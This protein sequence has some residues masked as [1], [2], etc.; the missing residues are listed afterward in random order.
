M[1]IKMVIFLWKRLLHLML[2]VMLM[3]LFASGAYAQTPLK[4]F[5]V[6]KGQIF[7]SLSKNLPEISLDS[8]IVQYDLQEL[9]LKKFIK[10]SIADSLIKYGWRIELNNG[11]MVVVSKSMLP[12]ETIN[13]PVEKILFAQKYYNNGSSFANKEPMYDVNRFTRKN[14][15]AVND[16]LVTFFL[17][18]NKKAGKVMLAGTFN[19]WNPD[20][21][22]MQA[23]DSGWIAVVELGA[24]KHY[25]KFIVDG[26]WTVDK[27]NQLVENDGE[28]N[29]NS[30]YF[31][32]NFK[33]SLAAFSSAKK[34]YI[35][36][37]FNN[38]EPADISMTKTATGWER[39]VYLAD[40]THTYRF[41]ADG[42]WFADP[43]N[44]DQFPNEFNEA[45]SVIRKGR[46]IMFR[47][48][49]FRNAKQVMLMGSFNQ[50]RNFE[51]KMQLTDSGW[52][53]PYTLG[54]G[55][56]EYIFEADGK[57]IVNNSGDTEGENEILVIAPNTNFRLK[58]FTNAKSVYLAGDFNNWSPN[59]FAMKR[60]GADWVIEQHLLPGK[61][62]YKFV[63]DGK[64]IVDTDNPLREPNEFGE[65]NSVIWKEE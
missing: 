40:G 6:K 33:F 1:E 28:G 42:K 50:W 9:D 45:N 23:V 17:R 2:L 41:V 4:A 64:W 44:P 15:F 3:V 48:N 27:D 21:L 18:N 12:L 47:L 56:Y 43:A 57:K 29:D 16:S 54:H 53:L 63:V 62:I 25:Y 65:E 26:N 39:A 55:N 38:W 59:G 22:A 8:F 34:V 35:S 13:D 51:L 24:G 31:K 49:G 5:V 11:E 14:P 32:T 61:H 36:G 20:A 30:V 60:D 10:T 7:I 58:G 19:N 52:V 37:S 46:P